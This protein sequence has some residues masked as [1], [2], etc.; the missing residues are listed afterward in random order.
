MSQPDWLDVVRH[1]A[2]RIR[3]PYLL[4]VQHPAI[5]SPTCL[6]ALVTPSASGD[7][8][9]LAPRL[10]FDGVVYRARV[11]DLSAIQVTLLGEAVASLIADRDSV[12]NAIAVILHGYPAGLSD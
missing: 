11:L 4:V 2:R 5:P 1:R 6:V 9:I 7:V 8:D 3:A 10:T 12:M